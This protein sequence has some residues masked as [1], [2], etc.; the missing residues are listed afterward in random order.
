MIKKPENYSVQDKQ[1][2]KQIL[3]E[4]GA[5]LNK[6]G[7]IKKHSSSY[8]YK[9]VI[10]DMFGDKAPQTSGRGLL[11]RFKIAHKHSQMN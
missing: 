11:P 4:S 7:R 2:Y 5:H 8:K 1:A 10:A 6:D 3:E 9:N